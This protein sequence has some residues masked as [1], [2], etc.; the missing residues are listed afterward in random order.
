MVIYGNS[1]EI[2]GFG[3][4]RYIHVNHD[5]PMFLLLFLPT[6]SF[7]YIYILKNM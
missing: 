4:Y 7:F 6:L 5:S 2:T 3:G 1:Y